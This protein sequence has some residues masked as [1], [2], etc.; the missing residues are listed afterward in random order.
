MKKTSGYYHI[1]LGL[2][3]MSI[4]SEINLAL[5]INYATDPDYINPSVTQAALQSLAKTVQSDLGNRL[6]EPNLELTATQKQDVDAL[7]RALITVKSE[8]EVVANKKALGNRN[9]FDVVIH[10]IGFNGAKPHGTHIHV[11][12]T[13]GIGKGMIEIT[14]PVENALGNAT[15]IFQY[16]IT[17]AFNVL[18]A[19]WEALIPLGNADV[20]LSGLP[21]AAIVVVQYAVVVIPSHKKSGGGTGSGTGSTLSSQ[22]TVAQTKALTK[23]TTIL[24]VNSKGKVQLTHGITFYYFSDAIYVVVP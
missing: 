7:S 21:S 9:I 18:P 15:Y 1:V 16:G 22:K 11:F 24:P 3:K 2:T 6:T 4:S 5:G 14:G 12:E 19:T 8:V 20:I 10:R 17:T 13:K 23:A